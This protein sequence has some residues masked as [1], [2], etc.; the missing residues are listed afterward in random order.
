MSMLRS[1][2]A[3]CS[4]CRSR[5]KWM[6]MEFS[7]DLYLAHAHADERKLA[8]LSAP[9]EAWKRPRAQMRI[10]IGTEQFRCRRHSNV[11]IA[12]FHTAESLA[13]HPGF[14]QPRHGCA[15]RAIST[16]RWRKANCDRNRG[17]TDRRGAAA[18]IAARRDRQCLQVGDLFRLPLHPFR[19]GRVAQRCRA[20]LPGEHRA[21][22]PAGERRRVRGR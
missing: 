2:G 17:L 5:G 20:R 8:H 3:R 21:P 14:S 11:P 12:E 13:R 18:A 22:V 7:G 16:R 9:G 1:P 10:V 4:R 15:G 6:V 19:L